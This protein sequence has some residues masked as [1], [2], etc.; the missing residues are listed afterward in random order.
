MERRP[1][2]SRQSQGSV[3]RPNAANIQ[4][5]LAQK[6]AKNPHFFPFLAK[7]RTHMELNKF[8]C[9]FSPFL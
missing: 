2:S 1:G 5:T 4:K 6:P 9:T 3:P 7:F 8:F